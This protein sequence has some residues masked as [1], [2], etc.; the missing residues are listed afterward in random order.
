MDMAEVP[1]KCLIL[2]NIHNFLTKFD[3]SNPVK[4]EMYSHSRSVLFFS[5]QTY[6]RLMAFYPVLHPHTDPPK[7][8]LN[9]V[10][11]GR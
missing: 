10:T 9:L 4:V 2:L 1:R 5:H 7:E 8:K 6:Q 3:A 11:R